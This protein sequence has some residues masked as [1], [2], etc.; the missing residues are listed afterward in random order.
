MANSAAG[1]GEFWAEPT[2]AEPRRPE[3]RG[4][5]AARAV[6]WFGREFVAVLPVFAFFLVT[7]V[8]INETQVLMGGE[9]YPFAVILVAAGVIAKAT[10]VADHLPFIDLFPGRPLVYNVAWKTLIYSLCVLAVRFLEKLIRSSVAHGGLAEGFRDFP[11]EMPWNVFWAVQVAFTGLFVVY[12]AFRELARAIGMARV[13]RL[14]LG[15]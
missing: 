8:F 14:F 3:A 11:S 1:A 12:L 6:R 4:G 5:K 10:L 2:G 7:V 15:M 13:R 9:R